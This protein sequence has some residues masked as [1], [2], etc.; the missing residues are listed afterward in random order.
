MDEDSQYDLE[1]ELSSFKNMQEGNFTV[2][3]QLSS[4]NKFWMKY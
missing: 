2:F 3:N 4:R 1:F